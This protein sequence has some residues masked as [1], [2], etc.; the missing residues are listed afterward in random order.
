MMLCLIVTLKIQTEQLWIETYETV[1]QINL[2]P[3][4]VFIR[5]TKVWLTQPLQ[6]AQNHNSLSPKK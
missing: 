3:S 5:A 1:S 4:G 2:F 6:K